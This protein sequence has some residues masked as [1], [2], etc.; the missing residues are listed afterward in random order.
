MAK[1]QVVQTAF[2][3]GE[4]SPHLL[5]RIDLEAYF[6]GCAGLSNFIPLPHGPILRRR[7]SQY[8]Y[9]SASEHV[10]LIPF[11]F[12]N[13]QSYVLEFTPLK[14]RIFHEGGIFLDDNHH[15]IEIT[16]PYTAYDLPNLSWAQQGDWLFIV[17]GRN[18]PQVLKRVDN[19]VW[20]IED[21]PFVSKPDDWHG[22]NQPSFVVLFEQRAFYASTPGQPQQIWASRTG[23]Y[24]DFTMHDMAGEPGKEEKV[25]LDDHAFTYTIFSNDVNGIK[26]IVSADVLLIGTA[27]A[28]F[29]LSSTSS[30]DPLTPKNVRISAQTNYGSAPVH[31]VRVG[32]SIIFTQRSRK[33]IRAFEYSFS[34]DQYTAQDLTIFASHILHG[35]VKEMQ[36]QSAPDS[37]IWIV[38]EDGKLVGCTYEKDQKVLAW[39]KHETDGKYLSICV[40]PTDGDDQIFVAVERTIN[41]QKKVFIEVFVNAWEP[42]DDATD[43]FYVDSGLSYDGPPIQN[44]VGLQHLEGKTVSILVDGWVH[45]DQKVV[46]GGVDLSSPGS[47]L[48]IGLPYKSYFLS[49]VPQSQQEPTVGM[50]RRI[51]EAVVALEESG[52]FFYKTA[53]DERAEI[54][55]SGP[56]R[57][58]NQAAELT[59][60]H[61]TINLMS[62]TERTSQL[63]L[64]QTRPLPLIIRGV[65]YMI[66]PRKI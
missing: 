33:R 46:N 42:V 16:T 6:A 53:V 61:H 43:A 48:H 56:T 62:K 25:V 20:T 28:E 32:S 30:L 50:V 55:Y 7:G 31:P 4:L 59:S 29:K 34:E 8:I 57:V 18:N 36:V 51:S 45:P 14:I 9:G 11:S 66:N 44:V 22:E 3:A 27:G 49:M 5:D 10:R 23:L 21:V 39:H 15:I 24:E 2:S 60:R 41:G 38:T 64:W 13:T 1:E 52:D 37:Y 58:M 12:S 54:A 63:E 17:D 26:W 35:R 47:K 65:V 19:T 40:L